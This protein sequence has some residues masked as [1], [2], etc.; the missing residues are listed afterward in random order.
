[1]NV[2]HRILCIYFLLFFLLCAHKEP[3]LH[4]DRVDPKLKKIVALNEHQ[5]MLQFSEELD[6]LSLNLE[7]FHILSENDTLM[8]LS[9][10]QGNT[11]DQIFL[12]TVRMKPIEYA[13]EGKVYD[14]SMRFGFFR[15][16]FTGSMRPDTIAPW[17]K[18]YSKG[19]RLKSF[20]FQFSEPV[21]TTSLK[22]RIF[23]RHNM[24][25]KWQGMSYLTIV[26]ASEADSLNYDT[27]YYL[28]LYN[29]KDFGGNRIMPFITTI[30]PDTIYEPLFMRG[31]AVYQEKPVEKGIAMISREKVVGISLLE[32]GEFL[33]EVRDSMGYFIQVYGDG[34]YG[35]DTIFVG[36]PNIIKL[37]PRA[38]DLDSV[39]N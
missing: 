11:P 23:P 7:N 8:L 33:F 20:F 32:K 5:V 6:T 16:K 29:L 14:K 15:G 21:D 27:T 12:Y 3:P 24:T 34:I 1:M 30:T 37:T 31:K 28:Y 26:P 2:S 22:Y 36:S 39:I 4:I 35:E 13:I 25:T 38:F 10:S 9:L 18:N 17:V 19:Y